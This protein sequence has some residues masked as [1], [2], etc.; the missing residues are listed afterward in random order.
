[1]INDTCSCGAAIAIRQETAAEELA[2]HKEWL[3]AHKGC[4]GG[5][6]NDVELIGS[7]HTSGGSWPP[8][9]DETKIYCQA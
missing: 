8:K 4:R 2:L 7:Y 1:M 3:S 6:I 9:L 5:G